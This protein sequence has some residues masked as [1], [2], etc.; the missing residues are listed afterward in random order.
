[1]TVS[2]DHVE[3]HLRRILNRVAQNHAVAREELGDT[4]ATL[5]RVASATTPRKAHTMPRH[6]IRNIH[7]TFEQPPITMRQWD[8]RAYYDGDDER[9]SHH[10]WGRTP[11]EALAD[12]RR[13]DQ[14]YEES[15][16]TETQR[17]EEEQL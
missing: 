9:S 8:W 6:Y 2:N 16:I 12:L 4:L 13:L 17:L 10:G 15:L 14:E 5:N 3:P 7:L 11:E 1:M